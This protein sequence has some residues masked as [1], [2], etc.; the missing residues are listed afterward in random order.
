MKVRFLI[1]TDEPSIIENGLLQVFVME[2]LLN[3]SFEKGN[4][5][6]LD[7]N[8]LEVR[9]EGDQHQL[10]AFK[11]ELEKETVAKFGSQDLIIGEK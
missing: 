1:T 11:K 3:S 4:A 10:E 6:P 7:N 2:K 5:L 9:I 8:T